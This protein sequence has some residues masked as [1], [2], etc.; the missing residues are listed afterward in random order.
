MK[1]KELIAALSNLDPELKVVTRIDKYYTYREAISVKTGNFD[2]QSGAFDECCDDEYYA[3]D[4][5]AI[6][7]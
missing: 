3:L 4:A 1:I 5:V 7:D 2:A 6:K